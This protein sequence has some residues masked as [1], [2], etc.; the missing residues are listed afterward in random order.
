ML[1][2]VK[3]VPNADGTFDIYLEYSKRDA[4][5]A[6]EWSGKDPGEIPP[7]VLET[8]R[9]HAKKGTYKKY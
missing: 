3:L 8:I 4:E 7:S 6:R 5:F 1:P 9:S 2:Y